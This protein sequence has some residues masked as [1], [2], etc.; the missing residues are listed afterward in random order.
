M[1]FV[2]SISSYQ[3]EVLLRKQSCISS[4]LEKVSTAVATIPNDRLSAENE[5]RFD[6]TANSDAYLP[7]PLEWASTIVGTHVPI[8]T[9][10]DEIVMESSVHEV[11]TTVAIPDLEGIVYRSSRRS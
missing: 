6:V 7:P 1:S 2:R 10:P 4:L 11:I 8:D 9:A 5:S 3:P